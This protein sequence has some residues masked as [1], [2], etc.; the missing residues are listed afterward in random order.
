MIQWHYNPSK[1]GQSYLVTQH[2]TPED[3]NP[4]WMLLILYGSCCDTWK[5]TVLPVFWRNLLLSSLGSN[6]SGY[7]SNIDKYCCPSHLEEGGAS[8]WA[9]QG[10]LPLVDIK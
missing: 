6:Y 2:H 9:K 5:W 7:V 4:H 8:A 10:L 1:G 3:L